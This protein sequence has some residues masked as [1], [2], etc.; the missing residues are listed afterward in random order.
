[1]FVYHYRIYD[2]YI[3][4][5]IEIVSLAVLGDEDE[6]WRP[7]SYNYSRW[8]C[9]L[10]FKFPIVKL[11]DYQQN[12]SSLAENNNPFAVVIMAYL[13]SKKTK[14]NSRARL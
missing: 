5:N 6:N 13:Q 9:Q 8:S 2:K 11:S 4:K 12:Y 1:M 10:T 3:D 7:T 14:K